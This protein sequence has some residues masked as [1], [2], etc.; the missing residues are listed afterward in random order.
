MQL[1]VSGGR[2]TPRACHASARQAYS[3]ACQRSNFGRGEM[4]HGVGGVLADELGIL[5]AFL[6]SVVRH[7][8]TSARAELLN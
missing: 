1:P 3:P 4:K 6:A 2:R 5:E 7:A 8:T